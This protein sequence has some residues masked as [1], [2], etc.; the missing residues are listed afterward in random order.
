MSLPSSPVT[1]SLPP[2]SPLTSL[3]P[4][5]I[6]PMQVGMENGFAMSP[7]A[8]LKMEYSAETDDASLFI[9]ATSIASKTALDVEEVIDRG[10]PV[11]MDPPL[12]RFALE[13]QFRAR[14]IRTITDMQALLQRAADLIMGRTS[15]F[16]VDPHGYLKAL[17]GGARDMNSLVMAWTA[18]SKRMTLAQ[19]N[20]DKYVAEYGAATDHEL[21]LSPVL[22]DPEIYRAF[23]TEGSPATAVNFLFDNV[24]HMRTLL[25]DGHNSATDWLPKFTP[26]PGYLTRAFPARSP[27][28]HP[29]TIYYSAA[30]EHLSYPT[31]ERSV[32][33]EEAAAGEQV[34]KP[35]SPSPSPTERAA[36]SRAKGKGK[37]M[38]EV[39]NE[40]DAPGHKRRGAASS[41]D[42]AWLGSGTP[43]KSAKDALLP[44]SPRPNLKNTSVPGPSLP[45][46][47]KGMASAAPY[48]FL[49]DSISQA[50]HDKKGRPTSGKR[51]S[52]SSHVHR[53]MLEEVPE[54]DEEAFHSKPAGKDTRRI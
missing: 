1:R 14:T 5:K 15:C 8:T 19:Q 46:P 39:H 30:G 35:R 34:E 52:A 18:L 31:F 27:E 49:G 11:G 45:N 22:T 37:E 25:P 26:V 17:L 16:A 12:P 38:E 4:P 41:S 21:L 3:T 13:P 36:K 40:K 54:V 51:A 50:L 42:R 47:L 9:R 20:F 7:M 28:E 43:F 6:R 24:P 32:G 44:V 23:P 48:N 29:S 33:A 10:I 53:Q 2:L